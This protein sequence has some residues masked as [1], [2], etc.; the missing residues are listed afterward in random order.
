MQENAQALSDPVLLDV[1]MTKVKDVYEPEIF[2]ETL[3]V[4]SS[5]G[6]PFASVFT[7]P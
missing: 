1:V 6:A 2:L 3:N 4:V 7:S 5:I